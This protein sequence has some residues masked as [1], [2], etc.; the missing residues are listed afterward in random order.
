MRIKPHFN[1]CRKTADSGLKPLEKQFNT[2][3]AKTFYV[4]ARC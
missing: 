3:F 2:D 4:F 1:A